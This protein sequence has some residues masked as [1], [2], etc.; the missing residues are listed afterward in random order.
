[1]LFR[2]S[3]YLRGS[4]TYSQKA[5]I[6]S[7]KEGPTFRPSL[8]EYARR[9]KLNERHRSAYKRRTKYY[10]IVYRQN[11]TFVMLRHSQQY[12]RWTGCAS[13]GPRRGRA[14]AIGVWTGQN[15]LQHCH[16]HGRESN[17][18]RHRRYLRQNIPH[19]QKL[20]QVEVGYLRDSELK[21]V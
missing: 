19:G 5:N 16:Q 3:R 2:S 12:L 15:I 9:V 1:M 11:L 13:H 18:N 10:D 21:A 20:G 8:L 7:R 17:K 4:K 6:E 14:I